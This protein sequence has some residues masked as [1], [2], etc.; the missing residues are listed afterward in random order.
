LWILDVE[1]AEEEVLQGMDFSKLHIKGICMEC[2]GKDTEK[3]ARKVALLNKEG[4]LCEQVHLNCMCRHK[5]F[6]PSAKK[7]FV[8]NVGNTA[9]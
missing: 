2:D 8:E 7:T 6:E 4:Y 3:D 5:S 9:G 1:G